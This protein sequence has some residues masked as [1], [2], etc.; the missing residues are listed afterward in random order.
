MI[1]GHIQSE[2]YEDEYGGFFGKCVFQF[3]G[4]NVDSYVIGMVWGTGT[5]LFI[6][7]DEDLF[8][9]SPPRALDYP[10]KKMTSTGAK[11]SIDEEGNI[12]LSDC[13]DLKVKFLGE[14]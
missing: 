9:Y 7:E 6:T 13:P 10:W 5:G 4:K 3:P 1:V 12:K 8:L 11:V 14:W 2:N